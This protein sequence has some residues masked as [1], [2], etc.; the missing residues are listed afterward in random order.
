MRAPAIC[1]NPL[2]S[3]GVHM[4]VVESHPCGGEEGVAAPTSLL[5][6]VFLNTLY[7]P[8]VPL[9]SLQTYCPLSIN[10]R[11]SDTCSGPE[12]SS[13]GLTMGGLSKSALQALHEYLEMHDCSSFPM[14]ARNLFP[15]PKSDA[16][17]CS[18]VISATTLP[19]EP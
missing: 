19:P 3:I 10:M 9:H 5:S 13:S 16:F 12:P 6:S 15:T 18:S 1:F 2:D 7:S 17:A 4:V 8:I 14:G 11:F